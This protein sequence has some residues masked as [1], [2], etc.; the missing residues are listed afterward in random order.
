MINDSMSN[1]LIGMIQPK[2]SNNGRKYLNCMMW[3]VL[4]K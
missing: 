1:K 3:G 2:Y 4:E